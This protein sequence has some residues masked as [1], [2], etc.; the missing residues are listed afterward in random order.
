MQHQ[1]LNRLNLCSSRPVGACARPASTTSTVHCVRTHTKLDRIYYSADK[2]SYDERIEA[3][4]ERVTRSS[5]QRHRKMTA[6]VAALYISEDNL[7]EEITI[8]ETVNN[9]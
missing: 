8:A 5:S 1:R 3:T 4:T 9:T 7:L 6:E 2:T